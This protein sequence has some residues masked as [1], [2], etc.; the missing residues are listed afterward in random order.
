[1]INSPI[2][3]APPSHSGSRDQAQR[4]LQP[5]PTDLSGRPVVLD[6]TQMEVSSPSFLDEMVKEVL[7][8]RAAEVFEIEG[9]SDRVQSLLQRSA[10]NRG[11]TERLRIGANA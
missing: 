4:L 1:M 11:V 6:C 3:L 5:L 9:A 8:L 7:V 2:R 10:D